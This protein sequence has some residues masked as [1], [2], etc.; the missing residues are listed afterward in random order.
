MHLSETCIIGID[1]SKAQ[2]DVAVVP[3]E[4]TT[5]FANA[6]VGIGELVAWVQTCHPQFIVVEATGGLELLA[7]G[8]LVY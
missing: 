5:Q 4:E 6:D 8:R 3:S 7:T 1:V 2:L